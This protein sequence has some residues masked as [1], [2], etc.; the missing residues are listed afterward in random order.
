ME[1][2]VATLTRWLGA[3]QYERS[4]WENVAKR[5]AD[6]AEGQLEWYAG[7]A[8]ELERRLIEEAA[9]TGKPLIL[10]TVKCFRHSSPHCG[11]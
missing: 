4:Y 7:K 10:S 5:I 8:A 11:W 6:G 3:Q 9:A 2:E 1:A